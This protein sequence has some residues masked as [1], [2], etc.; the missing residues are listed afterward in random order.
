MRPMEN[1]ER[2][3]KGC[4]RRLILKLWTSWP[5]QL[6]KST[7]KMF[8]NKDTELFEA[9]EQ[10]ERERIGVGKHDEFHALLDQLQNTYL[11]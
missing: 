11:T 8:S 2:F 1:H 6:R 4:P 5:V 10:L 7:N 3:R 9:F